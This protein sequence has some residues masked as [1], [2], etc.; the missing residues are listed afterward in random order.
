MQ[1]FTTRASAFLLL[2]LLVAELSVRFSWIDASMPYPR[3]I[4]EAQLAEPARRILLTGDL[5]PHDFE[6]PS[7]PVY[8]VTA[9][10]AVGF[11]HA[12][13]TSTFCKLDGI[14]S[15]TYPY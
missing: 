13:A 1:T 2:L 10:F 11:L 8:L 5:D 6:Y 15:V 14:G 7:L 12:C 4:D 9:S 3:H